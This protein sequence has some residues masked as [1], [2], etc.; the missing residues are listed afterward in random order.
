MDKIK[1][2]LANSSKLGLPLGF[3]YLCQPYIDSKMNKIKENSFLPLFLFDSKYRIWRHLLFIIVGAIITFNQVFI[4]YQ[5]SQSVLGNRIYLICFSSFV[6]YLIA[7]YFNYFYLAPKFLL[8]GKYIIYAIVLCIIVFLLPTV[9]IAGEYWIRN[10][11]DLPH[12]ITSYASPL[13]LIDNL[14]ASVITAICFCGISVIMLFRKWISGN[15]QVARLEGEHI[16]S[17]LNKLKGQITPAFLSKTLRNA[18]LSVELEPQ[19]TS[20]MLMQLGQLLRY[21]LYDCNRD[22]ILLKSE[23]DFLTKFIELEQLNNPGIQ[24]HIHIEGNINNTFVSPM[25]FISLVQCIITDSS[26]LDLSFERENKTLVFTCKSD[27]KKPLSN[28]MFSS[29]KQRLELQY[30]NKYTLVLKPEIVKLKIE[31]SE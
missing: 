21:Q 31:I 17:E 18:S 23:I 12:R 16:K 9:S 25:L 27:N 4:V 28:D 10:E 19:K 24:Y 22:R 3:H 29:I 14:S 20:N 30:S 1:C 26:V 6:L 7:M 8:N 11:L 5:D 15:E 13:I 2:A